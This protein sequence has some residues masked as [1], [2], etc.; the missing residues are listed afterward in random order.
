MCNARPA[1]GGLVRDL[2]GQEAQIPVDKN[3]QWG[4]TKCVYSVKKLDNSDNNQISG[5]QMFLNK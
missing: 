3:L 5:L 4:C 1:G 2:K